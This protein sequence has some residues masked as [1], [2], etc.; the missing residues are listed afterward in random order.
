MRER[1]IEVVVEGQG[2]TSGSLRLKRIILSPGV[3]R[4][5]EMARLAALKPRRG[6]SA[7]ALPDTA[8]FGMRWRRAGSL[9]TGPTHQSRRL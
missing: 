6:T 4:G 7:F 1:I 8:L 9:V 3:A 2:E 5:A